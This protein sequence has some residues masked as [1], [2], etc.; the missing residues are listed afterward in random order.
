MS[1]GESSRRDAVLDVLRGADEPMSIVEVAE[2]LDVHPNTVRFHLAA[3]EERGRVER[4]T[5]P[6]TSPGRPAL[7]FRAGRGM[8]P[9]GPRS[10]RVL[11]EL[12]V[13]SLAEGP[14]TRERSLEAGRAWGRRTATASG[15]RPRSRRAVIRRLVALLADL[16]FAPESRIEG[17][18]QQI[19]LRHCPF[20]ELV[21][22]RR[23]VICP[24][25]LGLMQGSLAEL[26]EKTGETEKSGE[27]G[28]TVEALEPFVEPDLCLAHLGGVR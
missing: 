11:A 1:T 28:V 8:D 12:L 16:G 13:S 20:L 19:M 7:R 27:T 18:E 14:R 15:P 10:Y 22:Q 3:L 5:S 23:D 2:R 24:V 6:T 17:G 26:G 4:A 25:H 9:D 21:D